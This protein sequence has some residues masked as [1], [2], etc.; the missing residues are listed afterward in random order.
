[1]TCVHSKSKEDP[2][3]KRPI[4]QVQ[5]LKLEKKPIIAL[6]EAEDERIVKGALGAIELGIADIILVG[7]SVR[8]NDRLSN[9]PTAPDGTLDIL[10][11]TDA[12]VT[13]KLAKL[14]FDK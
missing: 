5:S 10:D 7:N 2:L 4:E 8:I 6:G 13:G 14:F 9:F 12:A 1:M 3:I 11:S